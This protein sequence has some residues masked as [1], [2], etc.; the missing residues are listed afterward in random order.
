[1]HDTVI[2]TVYKAGITNLYLRQCRMDRLY[3][4][5][6]T[7]WSCPI[8]RDTVVTAIGG[9]KTTVVTATIVSIAV[10][11]VVIAT[12]ATL[13]A[14]TVTLIGFIFLLLLLIGS[15]TYGCTDSGATCHTHDGSDVMTT[16]S[17]GNASYG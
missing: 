13:I 6:L 15:S 5:T 4:G 1:M 14:I 7:L 3:L 16:P 17:A 12:F 8:K 10:T 9:I 2:I 11:V